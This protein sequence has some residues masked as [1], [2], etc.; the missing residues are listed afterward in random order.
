[1]GGG[2]LRYKRGPLGGKTGYQP[3]KDQVDEA[4]LA[5]FEKKIQAKKKRKEEEELASPTSTKVAANPHRVA[6]GACL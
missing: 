5:P 4:P 3:P 2:F 1:M 6:L